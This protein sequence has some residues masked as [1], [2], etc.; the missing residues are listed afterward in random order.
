[1]TWIC[2][3]SERY[4]PPAPTAGDQPI[5]DA[6]YRV[7][8]EPQE[9]P[10]W[11]WRARRAE[12]RPTPRTDVG[13]TLKAALRAALR[14]PSMLVPFGTNR[15]LL[16][17]LLWPVADLVRMTAVTLACL[18]ILMRPFIQFFYVASF[19]AFCAMW[20]K[21]IGGHVQPAGAFA[22][23][24]VALGAIPAI[25]DVI[26]GFIAPDMDWDTVNG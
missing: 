1:M 6:E 11:R 20:Y 19:V 13:S 16:I 3:E 14:A 17:I 26:L 4:P 2:L 21:I 9:R 25:W 23:W 12:P 7:I 10:R 15:V 24:S 18:M 5:I 8:H 22:F